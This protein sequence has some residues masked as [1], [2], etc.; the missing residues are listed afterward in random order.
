MNITNKWELEKGNEHHQ[1]IIRRKHKWISP[2]NENQKK[3]IAITMTKI[4][5]K[6]HKCHHH[7]DQQIKIRRWTSRQLT[8][9]KKMNITM[10]SR[11]KEGDTHVD[12]SR[13]K[14]KDKCHHYQQ[15][16]RKKQVSSQRVDQKHF[17][18]VTLPTMSC[19]LHHT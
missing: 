2:T 12:K 3:K 17:Y 8:N 11:S 14:E 5:K 10:I 1:H 7:C 9:W 6:G 19:H 18:Q 13:S 15:I 16:K 4:L